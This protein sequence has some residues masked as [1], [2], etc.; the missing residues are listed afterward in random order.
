VEKAKG[1]FDDHTSLITTVVSIVGLLCGLVA[2]RWKFKEHKAIMVAADTNTG[3]DD[4][5]A[6]SAVL[7]A[8]VQDYTV[9]RH[10][11]KSA[12]TKA[13]ELSPAE[14]G[15]VRAAT[16]SEFDMELV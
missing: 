11:F 13:T 9:T 2:F 6:K 4:K 15:A 8:K 16:P 14:A 3:V 5:D 10:L 7:L 12:A 1:F